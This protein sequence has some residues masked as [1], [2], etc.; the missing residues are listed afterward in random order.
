MANHPIISLVEDQHELV[1]EGELPSPNVKPKK[2]T[3]WWNILI[4]VFLVALIVV[5]I[6]VTVNLL[7]LNNAYNLSFFV[8]GMSM[9]PTLNSNCYDQN[10]NKL[11]WWHDTFYAGDEVEYGD[12][13]SGDKDNWRDSLARHD[14]VITYYRSDYLTDANNNLRRDANGNLMLRANAKSKIKRLVGFPGETVSIEAVNEDT[15]LYN[16]AWGKT[17][18]NP[19]TE[20]EQIIKPLYTVADYPSVEGHTYRFYTGS[21][22]VTLKEDEYCV[23]GDNRGAGYS[24]DSRSNGPVTSEMII[25][26]A[27]LVIGKRRLHRTE[28]GDIE[29]ENSFFYA[30][31]PWTYRRLD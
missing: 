27:Y 16:R 21:Y 30:F 28:S 25:G 4:D 17:T 12:G 3:R 19:G 5:S 24:G 23:I 8:N 29:P 6:S 15:E 2:K 20:S 31:V 7:Y 26:K 9:Y 13:K 1:V 10:G 22:T 18:I 11:M 14:I